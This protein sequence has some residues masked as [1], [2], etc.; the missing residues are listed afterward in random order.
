MTKYL[1][2]YPTV[3]FSEQVA[4]KAMP[5]LIG[6]VS[7]ELTADRYTLPIGMTRTAGHVSDVAFSLLSCGRVNSNPLNLEVD[8][9]INGT[10]CLTTKPKITAVTGAASEHRT[11]IAS[12]TGIVEAVIDGAANSFDAGDIITA[13]LD[14]TRTDTPTT[15][16]GNFAMIVELEP[17]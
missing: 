2:P 10:T 3:A 1:G 7:G 5:P 15:E 12:G 13:T 11:T 8:V 9:L 16:M 4:D 17:D 14:I 6:T